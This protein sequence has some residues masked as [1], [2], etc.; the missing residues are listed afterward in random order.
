MNQVPSRGVVRNSSHRVDPNAISEPA[1][2]ERRE[3]IGFLSGFLTL[4][5]IR[6]QVVA[7]KYLPVRCRDYIGVGPFLGYHAT[8][9][10]Q[11]VSTSRGQRDVSFHVVGRNVFID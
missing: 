2:R 9:G 4:T 3:Q 11:N 1:W 7:E 8:K 5:F 6:N 10:G